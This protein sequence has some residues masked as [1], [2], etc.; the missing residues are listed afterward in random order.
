[1]SIA[2]IRRTYEKSQ[3]LEETVAA[4][5]ITQVGL[6]FEEALAEEVVEPTAMTLASATPQGKPSAR[7]VLLKGYDERG[8]VFYTN[9]RSRKGQELTANPQA[10]LLFFWPQL[11]RQV[12]LEGVVSQVSSEESDLYFH[13]RPLDSRIGAWVSAQ[14]RPTTHAE[15]EARTIELAAS[16]G[17]HPARPAHWGGY[18]LVPSSIEF[19]QGRPSR[20]HDRLVF[21]RQPDSSWTLQRLAP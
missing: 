3:L 7:I 17:E 21:T 8:F 13:S 2:D 12:R 10:S 4:D 14:S 5:P 15:L 9:Y 6:W 18:R 1:M 20:L 11:E 19:W 16:L